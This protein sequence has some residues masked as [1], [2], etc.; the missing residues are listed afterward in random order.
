MGLLENRSD[1]LLFTGRPLG[2]NVDVI[3]PVS[4]ELFFRSSLEHTDFFLVLCDVDLQGQCTNICDGY[5]RVRPP[6][7]RTDER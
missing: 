2:A 5:L 3:G 1:V 6:S 7:P 4:A